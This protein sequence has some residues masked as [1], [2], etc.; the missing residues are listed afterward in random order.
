[1]KML[2]KQVVVLFTD[3]EL[4]FLQALAEKRHHGNLSATV[5]TLIDERMEAENERKN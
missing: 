2:K 1:M 5:R 4:A 3:D